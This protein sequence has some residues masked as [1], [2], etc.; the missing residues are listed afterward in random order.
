MTELPSSLPG[1]DVASGLIRVARN[2]KLYVKLLRRV[3]SEAPATTEQILAAIREG[4]A[5]AVREV[6]HSLKGAAANLSL[7]DVTLAAEQ[8]E[9]AAK[10]RE[11]GALPTHLESL[12]AA[13]GS[14]V[15]VVN[16]LEGL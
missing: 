15:E 6:A 14:F 12:K 9:Q 8:L 16:S 4:N 2:Q 11:L 3:A 7:T 5:D 10:N 1:I 13:L